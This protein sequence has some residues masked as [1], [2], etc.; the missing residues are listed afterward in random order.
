MVI[1]GTPK[2]IDKYVTVDNDE[3]IYQLSQLGIFPKYIDNQ[4][5]YFEKQQLTLDTINNIIY[6]GEIKHWK[7]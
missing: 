5:A 6:K 3:I 4:Q 2:N 1:R 7:I